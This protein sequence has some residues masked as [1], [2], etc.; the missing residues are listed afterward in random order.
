MS[1]GVVTGSEA[2]KGH[3]QSSSFFLLPQT[4]VRTLSPELATWAPKMSGRLIT[5]LLCTET[6]HQTSVRS[7]VYRDVEG[8][9]SHETSTG[10]MLHM[11]SPPKPGN[12][13]LRTLHTSITASGRSN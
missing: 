7:V 1:T 2:E 6:R 4:V 10:T 8:W 5:T 11:S 12:N 13:W 9:V 3:V